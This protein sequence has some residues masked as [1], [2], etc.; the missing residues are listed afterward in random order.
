M[1]LFPLGDSQSNQ[2]QPAWDE[3]ASARLFFIMYVH[4]CMHHAS[5]YARAFRAATCAHEVEKGD[6]YVTGFASRSA[7]SFI[8]FLDYVHYTP[9]V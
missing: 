2:S 4:V 7:Q 1:Y 6:I 8:C 5:G 3:N 9:R